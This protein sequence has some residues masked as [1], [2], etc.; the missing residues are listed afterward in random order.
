MIHLPARVVTNL[1]GQEIHVTE[2]AFP[3]GTQGRLRAPH[4]RRLHAQAHRRPQGLDA[5]PRLGRGE[6]PHDRRRGP[7]ARASP[8]ACRKS[9]SRRTRGSSSS[10]A[11]SSPS[12]NGDAARCTWI[13]C[14]DRRDAGRHVRAV[15]RRQLGRAACT[16]T[17]TSTQLMLDDDA[18]R[19]RPADD[20]N[21]DTLTATLTNRRLL[22]RL[23]AFVR[24]EPAMRRL[25]DEAFTA[26]LAAQKHLLRGLFTADARHHQQHARTRQP[27]SLGL[28]AGHPA[29]PAGLRR[30]VAI[31]DHSTHDA[32]AEPSP[33][34]ACPSGRT[35]SSRRGTPWRG[36][37]LPSRGDADSRRHG[38]RI[39]PGSLRSFGK[40]VGLLPGRKLEQL[41]DRSSRSRH[42]ARRPQAA[43]EL[44]PRRHAHAHRPAAGLRPH[45][46][47]HQHLRRQRHHR[48]QL[49]GVHVPRRHGLQPGVAERA[50]VLRRRAPP[51]RHRRLQARASASGRSC[52]KS[53]C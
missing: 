48:A 6:G 19:L 39:D 27:T 33:A 14:L 11:C 3:T 16:T 13:S 10:S 28:L 20:R 29:D 12:A 8:R 36:G 46:A 43:G 26:G 15:R 4:R 25:S 44:G 2:G 34:E 47:G 18:T 52:W 35:D 41:A 30:A 32:K 50:H 45:R 49:L 40:H 23:S 7:P 53:P 17:T 42:R 5:Q 1:D 51:L 21:G 38:L 9:A 31:I 22:S 37:P 24:T